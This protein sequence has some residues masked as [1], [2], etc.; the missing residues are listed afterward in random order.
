MLSRTGEYALRAVVH[1]ARHPDDWPIPGNRIAAAT[2]VPAKYLS[3]ILG[4]LVRNGVLSATPGKRGGFRMLRLP[5]ETRLIDVLEPFEQFEKR[6]C[7]F[8]HTD[9]GDNN[10]CRMHDQ[11]RRIEAAER[12]FL[13]TKSVA[14][15]SAWDA[16][17]LPDGSF[18]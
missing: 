12:E 5:E 3:K 15:V 11:W 6:R 8:H 2:G 16:G 9:C 1:L 4:D 7:P 18:A 17:E 10:P 13:E 14:D